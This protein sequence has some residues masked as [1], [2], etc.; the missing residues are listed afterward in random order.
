MT[1]DNAGRTNVIP[2]AGIKDYELVEKYRDTYFL[3]F[4]VT[5]NE[6]GGELRQQV[7]DEIERPI[8]ERFNSF[9]LPRLYWNLQFPRIVN[10][11]NQQIVNRIPSFH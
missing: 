2:N 4:V 1:V 11:S 3:A 9:R 5:V 6:V 7:L 8:K 10:N